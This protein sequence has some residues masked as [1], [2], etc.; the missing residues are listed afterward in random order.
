MPN[1][2]RQHLHIY[3]PHVV[4][5]FLSVVVLIGG[6]NGIFSM[7]EER[8]IERTIEFA[9]VYTLLVFMFFYV[10]PSVYGDCR[11]W[12]LFTWRRQ[13]NK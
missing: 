11:P 5:V 8:T 2:M 1:I 13:R 4:I 3:W 10:C 12:Q 7:K 6:L 9:F